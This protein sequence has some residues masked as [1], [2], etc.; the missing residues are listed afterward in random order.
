MTE[1]EDFSQYPKSITELKSDKTRKGGD[2]TVRDA[3]IAALRDL[4]S[5]ETTPQHCILIFGEIDDNV[6]YTTYYNCTPNRYVLHGMLADLE[7]RLIVKE[8]TG[9]F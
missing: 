7:R 9:E 6:T 8:C 2:W 5:G 3:L 4:D 1:T